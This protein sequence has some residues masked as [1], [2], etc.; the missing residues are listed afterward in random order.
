VNYKPDGRGTSD[1]L[2]EDSC[3]PRTRKTFRRLDAMRRN[4]PTRRVLVS[5]AVYR[6]LKASGADM[7]HYTSSARETPNAPALKGAVQ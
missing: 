2:L 1:T 5:P 4:G 3:P 7:R 6:M